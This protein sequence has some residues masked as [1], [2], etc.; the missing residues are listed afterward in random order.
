MIISIDTIAR[1]G[2]MNMTQCNEEE[3]CLFCLHPGCTCKKGQG[4]VRIYL[5]SDPDVDEE[6]GREHIVYD[7]R[8]FKQHLRDVNQAAEI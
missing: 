3:V 8:T 4:S 7:V 6:A 2:L 5:E 1:S